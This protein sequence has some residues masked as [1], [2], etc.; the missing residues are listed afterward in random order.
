MKISRHAAYTRQPNQRFNNCTAFSVD[1][2]PEDDYYGFELDGDHLYMTEDFTVQHNSGKSRI[3]AELIRRIITKKNHV[4]F[5]MLTHVKELIE[6]NA[7]RIREVWPSCPLGIYS[8]SVGF[9]QFSH[10][11]IFGGVQSCYKH[12][13]RFGFIHVLIIDEAH[14]VSEKTE[15]MYGAMIA[16]LKQRNPDLVVLGLTA[17][18]YR[19]GMGHLTEGPIFNDVFYDNTTMDDFVKLIDDGFLCDLIPVHT[20]TQFDLSE[21]KMSGG[22]FQEKSLDENL[23]RDEIT[24]AIVKET[25]ARAQGRNKGLAF[26]ISKSHAENMAHRFN[27]VGW[28]STFIHSDLDKKDRE[29]RLKDYAMGKYR[30]LCNVGVLTTGFDSPETDF[31]VIARPT[32]STSLHVQIM[33]R[34]MR[35]HKS[36]PNTLVLDFAGNTARLG[37]VNDPVL[38]TKKGEA[39]GDPPIRI[40]TECGTI[41]HAAARECKFCGHQFPPPKVKVNHVADSSELIRR[42]NQPKIVTT[43]VKS[44]MFNSH[45][46]HASGANMIKMTIY[47]GNFMN[48]VYLTFDTVQKGLYAETQRIMSKLKFATKPPVFTNN[49]GAIEFLR[50]YLVNPNH[51]KVWLNKPIMGKAK[52]VKHVLEYIYGD[53]DV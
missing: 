36:K 4:R 44:V 29:Q 39:K 16:G 17:T 35:P 20:S 32:Q 7:E 53:V 51:I 11:I 19:L 10:P 3:I 46:N 49:K 40:C 14:L 23:N 27:E 33:G 28:S 2:L 34:G 41:N 8:A 26:C 45:T 37:P 43:P 25:V 52:K 50:T 12:P 22:D 21:V 18:P 31:L 5:M 6:Q 13:E 47:D 15:S 30:V 48:D 9:K 24:R 42:A 1:G 38:P